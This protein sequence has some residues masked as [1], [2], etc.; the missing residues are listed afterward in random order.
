MPAAE[1]DHQLRARARLTG[2]V[3]MLGAT[4]CFAC[5]DASAKLLNRSMAPMQTLTIR[6]LGSFLLV[7]LLLNPRTRP[8]IL[9]TSR[10]AL[11]IARGLGLVAASVCLFTALKFLPLTSTTSITF[12]APLLVALLARPLLGETLGPR[13]FAAVVVGFCG[14]LVLTQPWTRAFHPAMALALLCAAITSLYTIVTRILATNDSPETTMFYTGLVGAVAVLPIVPFVWQTPTDKLAWMAMTTMSIPS[15]N[16]GT[17]NVARG[18]P[19]RKSMPTTPMARPRKSEIAP[20]SLEAPRTAVTA[21]RAN[22]MIA[23]Y[24]GAPSVTANLEI[25]GAKAANS[26]VPIAPA[27]NDPIAA[28]ASACAARPALAILLP[29]IAVMTDDDSPGV[30]SRMEVVEP[31]YM[32]P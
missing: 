9:R 18:C 10:P 19:V 7:A 23:R 26:T 13:R 14:V 17:P 12:S 21:T 20:R 25:G 2:I 11:Q 8:A 29:S 16:S 1:I 32:P 28:V 24:D 6:Y 4:M 31:P 5:I 3:L 22:S 27:T 15:D 30:F